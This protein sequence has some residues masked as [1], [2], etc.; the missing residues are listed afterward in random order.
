MED[1]L[2]L[3]PVDPLYRAFY[4]DGSSLDVHA[5]VDAM[6]AEIERVC[7]AARGRRLPAVRRLRLAS[8]TGCE[9]RDFIDRNID[10]PLD[11][12][13]PD[14]R[15]AGGARRVPAA[16]AEGRA[17]SCTTRAPQRVFSFQSMYAGLSPYDALAIYAVIALHGLGGRRLLPAGRHARGAAG[18]GRGGR[19]ARRR[20]SRYG[21]R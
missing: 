15:P 12:L 16:G 6:A 9:M 11:L 18:A 10:S 17:S 1:W 3:H 13:T 14:P 2:D 21:A 19:E 8:S 5:D 20:A 7:G 4:P